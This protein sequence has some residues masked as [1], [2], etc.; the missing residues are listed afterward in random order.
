M[1]SIQISFIFFAI[2]SDK[3]K[4]KQNHLGN[5][6]QHKLSKKH[7]QQKFHKSFGI[8]SFHL[9]KVIPKSL[10]IKVSWLIFFLPFSMVNY[11]FRKLLKFW[12]QNIK[13]KLL[14]ILKFKFLNQ[15]NQT[16]IIYSVEKEN[17]QYS[18]DIL[19]LLM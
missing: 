7:S 18:Q 2:T 10:F 6:N 14:S 19:K 11:H 12:S 13:E 1:K 8:S 16:I 3:T 17:F 9:Q 15:I 4:Q 5:T